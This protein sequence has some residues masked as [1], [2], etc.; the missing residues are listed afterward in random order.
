MI[1]LKENFLHSAFLVR[2][3]F[4][5]ARIKLLYPQR[6]YLFSAQSISLL[7]RL[8]VSELTSRFSKSPK[9]QQ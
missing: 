7:G 5:C 4:N 8:Q 9:G 6:H 2:E 1:V 3:V